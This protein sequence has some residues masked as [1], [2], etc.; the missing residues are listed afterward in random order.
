MYYDQFKEE[1]K[2]GMKFS[3]WHDF[4]VL[5]DTAGNTVQ[6]VPTLMGMTLQNVPNQPYGYANHVQDEWDARSEIRDGTG[7][8]RGFAV[9]GITTADTYGIIHEYDRQTDTKVDDD[10]ITPDEM[11]YI[12]LYGNANEEEAHQ[13]Q[14]EANL[15]PYDADALGTNAWLGWA[16]ELHSSATGSYQDTIVLDAPL[17]WVFLNFDQANPANQ[18]L[19]ALPFEQRFV[20]MTVEALPGDYNGVDS[21]PLNIVGA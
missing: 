12:D 10:T 20:G 18:D 14:Q 1:K 2:A 13:M 16:G 21:V 17:G 19:M 4:R 5:P 6:E 7:T 11:P 3:R 15:P 8:T 9:G